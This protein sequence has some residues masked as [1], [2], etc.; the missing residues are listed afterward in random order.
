MKSLKALILMMA[1]MLLAQLSFASAPDRSWL[2]LKDIKPG[3]NAVT[4][5]SQGYKMAGL[6]YTPDNFDPKKS[7]PAVV[8]TTP[9]NQVKEQTGSIYAAKLAKQGMIALTFDNRGYGESEGE[10]RNYMYTP[11]IVEGITDAISFTRMQDFIDRDNI[12]GVGVCAGGSNIITSAL[13]DKRM[14]AVATVSGMMDHRGYLLAALPKEMLNNM[15]KAGNEAQQKYYE[16]G[17]PEYVDAFNYGTK[18]ADNM[19]RVVREGYDYYMSERGGSQTYKNF[20]R[21]GLA[22]VINDFPRYHALSMAPYLNTPYLGI[23]GSETMEAGDTGKLTEDFYEAASEPKEIYQIKGASHVSLYDIEEHV[24][25][26]V[27]RMVKFFGKY[28]TEK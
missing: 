18:P 28:T 13:T 24:D 3:K 20:S 22:F 12:F 27:D 15:F 9:L 10:L 5:E 8:L 21:D 17:V 14:N 4:F 1:A 23:Y 6:L 16:T 2:K 11:L 7:Y 19:P 25:Q 26:A